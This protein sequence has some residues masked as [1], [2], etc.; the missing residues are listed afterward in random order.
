MIK[1]SGTEASIL[2]YIAQYPGGKNLKDFSLRLGTDALDIANVILGGKSECKEVIETAQA[3]QKWA[4][5]P[6]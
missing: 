2:A 6:K 4:L 1:L 5:G 3:I